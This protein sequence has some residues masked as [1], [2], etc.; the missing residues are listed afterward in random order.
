M[1]SFHAVLGALSPGKEFFGGL[2]TAPPSMS[3]LFR[4]AVLAMCGLVLN[5]DLAA[6]SPGRIVGEITDAVSGRPIS[7][8][9]VSIAG[10]S[11]RVATDAAGQ[12]SFENVAAGVVELQTRAI[13]YIPMSI[14]RLRVEPRATLA[15]GMQLRPIVIELEPIEV[16][17]RRRR[18]SSHHGSLILTKENLPPGG[19]ILHALQGRV[20]SVRISGRREDARLSVR[21]SRSDVLYVINGTV[22]RPPLTFFVN[23]AEVE[24]VEILRGYRAAN[25]YRPSLNGETYSGVVLIWTTGTVEPMPSECLETS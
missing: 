19:D 13:A 6:Q 12:F 2:G 14:G 20:A 1:Q 11:V 23:S 21:G 8:A 7:G 4:F 16:F 18:P 5:T 25:E 10:T 22:I 9:E 17:A 24:C 15:I 3:A